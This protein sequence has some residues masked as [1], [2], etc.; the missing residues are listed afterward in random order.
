MMAVK[1]TVE[2]TCDGC[3]KPIKVR[4]RRIYGRRHNGHLF[5]ASVFTVDANATGI[6]IVKGAHLWGFD[7]DDELCCSEACALK[8]VAKNL[9][10]LKADE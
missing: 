9:K 6:D 10:K 3:K 7:S 1:T 8:V 2:Y 4:A 5:L